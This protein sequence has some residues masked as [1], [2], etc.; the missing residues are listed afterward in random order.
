M[1]IMASDHRG[2][3]L[4]EILK[5]FFNQ[6][7]IITIDVGSYS[8]EPV[9]YPDFARLGM[10]KVL[11]QPNNVGI[12]ICGSGIGMSMAANRNPNIRAALC[13]NTKMATL[14][15]KDN[16]ANVLCLP[17]NLRKKKAIAIV[18]VFLTTNFEG[19]RHARRLK[20]VADLAALYAKN[21]NPQNKAAK[22]AKDDVDVQ[23]SENEAK[24]TSKKMKNEKTNK[25]GDEK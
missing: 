5:S 21:L 10:D 12:F 23:N 9:D 16:D 8:R 17:G 6:E 2:F 19:G 11:E 7:N 15:R 22:N 4:K 1:I 14:A 13:L 24:K 18:K 3:L 25:G 20:K